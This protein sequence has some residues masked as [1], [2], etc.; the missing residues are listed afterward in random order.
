MINLCNWYTFLWK[1]HLL[2]RDWTNC[3]AQYNLYLDLLYLSDLLEIYIWVSMIHHHHHY[4]AV[5]VIAL[6]SRGWVKASTVGM[7]FPDLPL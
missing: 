1:C 6:V 5:A 3:A 2:P 7:L 4:T